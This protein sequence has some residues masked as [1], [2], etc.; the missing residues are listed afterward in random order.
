[1]NQYLLKSLCLLCLIFF[2]QRADARINKTFFGGVA[3]EGYD[4]VAYFTEG[5]PA[6]GKKSIELEYNDAE[7]RFASEENR[8]AFEADPDKYAPQFGGYCAW[9]VSEGYTA[10]I[11]P[12][13]WNIVEGKLYLNYSKKTRGQWEEDLDDN[14]ADGHKH[15]ARLKNE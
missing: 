5:K 1:M 10:G 15:W 7:W 3:I 4:P 9:A 14:I 12:D 8:K 6:K 13:V 2:V 11:D